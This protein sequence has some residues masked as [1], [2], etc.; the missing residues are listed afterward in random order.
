MSTDYQLLIEKAFLARE[1]AY[2]PYSNFLVGA[3][4]L[5]AGGKVY[6]GVNIECASYGGT[7]CAERSA[8]FSAVSAG[9][10]SFSA[11]AIVGSH[12][13]A[14][15]GEFIY[16]YPCGFCRQIMMEFCDPKTFR[17]LVARTSSEF[18][19]YTLEELLPMGFG[20]SDLM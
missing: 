12:R 1:G 4:L 10:R 17:I 5:T 3:A 14:K 8:F 16:A 15:P 7:V 19:S 9:E 18:E 2:A 20:P 6:K 11:I 13:D